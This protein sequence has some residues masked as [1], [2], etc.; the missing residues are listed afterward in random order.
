M[1]P[2]AISLAILLMAASAH[3]QKKSYPIF[4]ALD[5]KSVETMVLGVPQSNQL[6]LAQL[7][8]AFEDVECTGAN[9]HEQSTPQGST[10]LCTLPGKSTDTLLVAAH[11][12]R[13]G[14]G[15]SAIDDWSGSIMLPLLYRAL[16][17]APRQ[18]TYIF[19][20]LSGD[21][22][23]KVFLAS[24]TS[25]QRRSIKA[26]IALD[27][28]GLGPM[29]FYIHLSETVPTPAENSLRVQLFEAA[30]NQGLKPPESSIPGSWFHI[31]DTKEFRYHGIPAI[32]MH[33]VDGSKRHVPGSR[34]DNPEAIDANAYFASYMTLCYYLV[35]LDQVSA[36][37]ALPSAPSPRRGGRR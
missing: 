20:A 6:R 8:R 30:D 33:S 13:V 3:A 16:T 24:L 15:M 4:R 9:L 28:L 10:L 27:A 19:A 2:L 17:A 23:A 11:Y 32:L 21:E 37:S 12:R 18:Q 7:K 25:A 26:I 36:W 14:E 22:A 29:R 35:G 34:D 5:Q 31:D 1:R